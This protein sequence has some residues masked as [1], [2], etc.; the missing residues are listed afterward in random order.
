MSKYFNS[1]ILGLLILLLSSLFIF[2]CKPTDENDIYT[3]SVDISPEGSGNVFIEPVKALYTENE[4]VTLIANPNNGYS[5]SYWE[6]DVTSS[7]N[8]LTLL[9]D[10]N[11]SVKAVFEKVETSAELI[12]RSKEGNIDNGANPGYIFE[13]LFLE[14]NSSTASFEIKN[15]GS[16]PLL[17]NEISVEG[18]D[19]FSVSYN[20]LPITL[21][22]NNTTK[23]SIELNPF[24][25]GRKHTLVTIQSDNGIFNFGV[26]GYV[27]GYPEIQVFSNDGQYIP[28]QGEYIIDGIT[29]VDFTSGPVA[30]SINNNGNDDLII[31]KV[32]IE[33]GSNEFKLHTDSLFNIVTPENSTEFYITFSPKTEGFKS[34][35]LFIETNDSN[36]NPYYLNIGANAIGYPDVGVVVGDLNITNGKFPA[37][38]FGAIKKDNGSPYIEFDILNNGTSKLSID[39]VEFHQNWDYPD[40]WYVDNELEYVVE[41]G[42]YTKIYVRF[43]PLLPIGTKE[44]SVKIYSND[45]DESLF[46]FGVIGTITYSYEPEIV[47]KQDEEFINSEISIYDYDKIEVGENKTVTY[48]IINLGWVHPD[49]L[50]FLEIQEI[51]IE[52]DSDFIIDTT[53]IA[54]ILAREDETYFDVTFSPTSVGQKNATVYI[55][56][57]DA[58]EPV[59]SFNVTG[60]AFALPDIRVTHNDEYIPVEG[61]YDFG[62]VNIDSIGSAT[63]TI[64]NNNE[65]EILF[66]DKIEFDPQLPQFRIEINESIQINPNESE[67]VEIKFNPQIEDEFNTNLIIYNNFNDAY[68]INLKGEGVRNPDIVLSQNENE[69]LIG[70]TAYDFEIVNI[71][72]E[73]RIAIKVENNGN[74]ILYLENIQIQDQYEQFSIDDYFTNKYVSAGGSTE[75][76]VIF[77]PNRMGRQTAEVFIRNNDEDKNPFYFTVEGTGYSQPDIEIYNENGDVIVKDSPNAYNFNDVQLGFSDTVKF[78]IKNIGN[79]VLG[80]NS[81]SIIDGYDEQFILDD[82]SVVSELLPGESTQFLITYTPNNIGNKYAVVQIES[83]DPEDGVFIFGVTGTTE[84]PTDDYLDFSGDDEDLNHWEDLI[85]DFIG[86]DDLN[87]FEDNDGEI[88]VPLTGDAKVWVSFIFEEAGYKNRFGFINYENNP[89]P[90][91]IDDYEKNIIFN[92]ASAQNSGGDLITG[93]TVFLG[94]FNPLEDNRDKLAFWLHQNG[95]NNPNN[96]YWWPFDEG[97]YGNEDTQLNVDSKKHM[98]MFTDADTHTPGEKGYIVMGI[99]DLTNLG[100]RDFDDIIIIITVEPE[101][102]NSSFEDVVDTSNMITIDELET[103]LQNN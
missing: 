91:N 82:N 85:H 78:H 76:D 57:N 12:V 95:F 11:K 33:S 80:I 46:E 8:P 23:F 96:P 48:S 25:A 14:E 42:E 4:E 53:D 16:L 39:R 66:I 88:T 34:I 2:S 20:T 63:L 43:V 52:G 38:D 71:D 27:R 49:F 44:A 69:I 7:D 13:D 3:L 74:D 29:D 87:W 55:E 62:K 56:S 90:D 5:F 65:N 10:D 70:D 103:Y 61:E 86:D 24:S 22:K 37:Y 26:R 50:N 30:F 47:V 100:D 77:K 94:S 17:I 54:T 21:E 18:D 1:V 89:T 93:D 6:G 35:L 40:Y 31:N 68:P 98:I 92:N 58:D 45:R 81:L 83:N 64:E 28:N 67:D 99:E 73:E 101:D 32:G 41:P 84:V 36:K 59:F 9:I 75:F 102:S 60:E 79:E 97:T 72:E 15:I 19:N 51:Y